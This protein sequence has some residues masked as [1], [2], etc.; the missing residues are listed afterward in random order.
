MKEGI[1]VFKRENLLY[2]REEKE[3]Y[4]TIISKMHPETREL[5]I[6]STAMKI[7]ELADGNRTINEI[8]N[9][10]QQKYNDVS[11]DI[12]KKDVLKTL[13]SFT[14]LG[15]VEWI[16]ENPFLFIY[17]EPINEN[18]S[19]YIAQ[20]NDI[21]ELENFLK[22]NLDNKKIENNFIIYKNPVI[23]SGEYSELSLRQKLFSYNEE[24]FLLKNKNEIEGLLSI[25][26]P[27]FYNIYE[28][29][30]KLIITPINFFKDLL[31]YSINYLPFLVIRDITK[32]SVYESNY[33]ILN[34][35][36]KDL[37]IN[38]GFK[39]EGELKNELGFGKD[40]VIYSLYYSKDYINKINEQRKKFI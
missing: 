40:L 39:K 17:E 10:F 12:I 32:I 31:R 26:L 2:F 6:N 28:S 35:T 33:E 30:I 3:G 13:S 23:L 34:N 7:L 15:I 21:R 38:E 25:S 20:E 36:L 19:M 37:L 29:V 14:R 24:F 1:P 22:V 9:E 8:I 11:K 5:I 27:I 18:Y 4:F 16:N